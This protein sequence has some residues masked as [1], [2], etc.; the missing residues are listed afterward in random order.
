MHDDRSFPCLMRSKV[1]WGGVLCCASFSEIHHMGTLYEV[2]SGHRAPPPPDRS[3]FR[4]S[5]L[6]I[7][8]GWGMARVW[9]FFLVQVS[10]SKG[11]RVGTIK[12]W[13]FHTRRS[14]PMVPSVLR[15]SSYGQELYNVVAPC[16]YIEF[17]INKSIYEPR[18]A[19]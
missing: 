7:R 19:F 6:S 2:T 4:H 16:P 13:I 1:S 10:E 14:L 5:T 11:G 3:R 17:S 12:L 9:R 8:A 15:L 18:P